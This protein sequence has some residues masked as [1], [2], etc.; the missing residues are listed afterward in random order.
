MDDYLIR[1]SDGILVIAKLRNKEMYPVGTFSI[2][3]DFDIVASKIRKHIKNKSLGKPKVSFCI[4]D[5]KCFF[6][7]IS[8]DAKVKE[9]EK[10]I[11]YEFSDYIESDYEDEYIYDYQATNSV[12]GERK[13]IAIAAEKDEIERCCDIASECGM[14][15]GKIIPE[16]IAEINIFSKLKDNYILVDARDE[17]IKIKVFADGIIESK[18]EIDEGVSK[19]SKMNKEDEGYIKEAGRICANI[20]KTIE[21]F[22]EK[23]ISNQSYDV[24]LIGKGALI[25]P[26]FIMLKKSTRHKC[27][28]GRD[29]IRDRL[30]HREASLMFQLRGLIC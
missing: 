11:P 19:L 4:S 27:I 6:K 17:T 3:K 22:D 30:S 9:V 23:N 20:I 7:N 24:C 5:E 15:I 2:G 10:N 13:Y 21:Y 12:S 14:R 1:V 28:T 29:V 8:S 25:K 26:L 18:Y 16:S